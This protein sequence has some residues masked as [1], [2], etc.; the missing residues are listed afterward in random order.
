MVVEEFRVLPGTLTPVPPGCV[1][2][3]Q[4]T[5]EVFALVRERSS[6]LR[7]GDQNKL[8]T[9]RDR[10]LGGKVGNDPYQ[11]V[12]LHTILFS[13]RSIADA[14]GAVCGGL[15]E[16][17]L[18]DVVPPLGGAGPPASQPRD[19]SPLVRFEP[20]LQSRRYR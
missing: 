13:Y 18:F 1:V 12:R 6:L 11:L 4:P 3:A 5:Q 14:G 17:I 2:S 19:C 15:D 10:L 20:R 8:Q 16:R 7:G 9:V